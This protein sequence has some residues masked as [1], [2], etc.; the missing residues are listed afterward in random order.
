MRTLLTAFLVL[1]LASCSGFEPRNNDGDSYY[2]SYP[3]IS[4]GISSKTPH[5]KPAANNVKE[6]ND[7]TLNRKSKFS[8]L[9]DIVK[10]NK[11]YET[12]TSEGT[13]ISFK[14]TKEYIS[15]NKKLCKRFKLNGKEYLSCKNY[16]DSFWHDVRLF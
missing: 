6:Q 14:V 8:E 16:G 10:T 7:S 15:G 4:K 3:N 12:A 13:E 9:L 11:L 5:N 1:L 2:P